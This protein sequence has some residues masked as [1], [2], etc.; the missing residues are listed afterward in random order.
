MEPGRPSETAA[1]IAVQR[2]CAAGDPFLRRLLSQPDEP[3]SAWFAE[4]HAPGSL[5]E[6][7]GHAS[8]ARWMD[9]GGLTSI[10]TRKRFV[11]DEVRAALAE[12]LE[13]AVV[14]G[15]GYDP[16]A[17]LLRPEFPNVRFFEL[18]HPAT[19]A[20]KR[21]APGGARRAARRAGAGGRRLRGRVGGVGPADGTG[22][23]R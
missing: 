2:A 12:G 23:P 9:P 14:L 19:Q 4:E 8:R 1:R 13:Q 20:V 15:A 11:E 5:A 21:R 18:D 10:L 6:A 16:L 22:V 7:A 3:Y 17:L